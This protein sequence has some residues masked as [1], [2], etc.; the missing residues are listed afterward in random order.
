M[1]PEEGQYRRENYPKH[2]EFFALG[3]R[4]P[5]RMFLGPNGVGKS[6]SCGAFELVSHITG[7][8]RSWWPGKRYNRPIKAW[9]ACDTNKTLRESL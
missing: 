2:M 8:Y 4:K 9:A 1:F 7:E 3:A 6:E 5:Y